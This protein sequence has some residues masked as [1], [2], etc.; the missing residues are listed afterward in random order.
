MIN[1]FFQFLSLVFLDVIEIMLTLK[2]FSFISAIPFRFKRIF[3]LSLCIITFEVIFWTFAPSHFSFDIISLMRI[4][5]FMIVALCYGDV[6][7]KSVMI[8][9]AFFPIVLGSLILRFTTLFITPLFNISAESVSSNYLLVYGMIYASLLLTYLFVRFFNYDFTSWHH[10]LTSVRYNKLLQVTNVSMFVYYILLDIPALNL[11]SKNSRQ[12]LVLFYLMFLL[13]LL[14]ILDR[15]V[16][17]G[18][19]QKMIWQNEQTFQDLTHCS[20]RVESLYQENYGFRHEDTSLLTSLKEGID[21]EDMS[22]IRRVY[23]TVLRRSK[24]RLTGDSFDLESLA[25][26]Q[27]A[28]LKSIVAAK[29]IEAQEKNIGISVE[30]SQPFEDPIIESLDFSQLLSLLLDNAINAA[31]EASSPYLSVLFLDQG[32]QLTVIIQNSTKQEQVD[33]NSADSGATRADESNEGLARFRTIL[34][35]YPHIMLRTQSQDYRL[36]QTIEMTKPPK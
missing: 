10:H 36:T 21:Q 26:L 35:A 32:D 14:A 19:V 7:R 24:E 2:L 9:Y 3:Y 30:V 34:D 12:I 17:Q 5:F 8:F 28:A 15:H 18:L 16:K 13:S 6:R 1:E 4:L 27:H 33:L 20:H 29:L 31:L 25:N 23:E 22:S 11:S